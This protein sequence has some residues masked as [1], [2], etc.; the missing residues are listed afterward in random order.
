MD[1]Q[2]D[3]IPVDDNLFNC[4]PE[5]LRHFKEDY[6]PSGYLSV[7]HTFRKGESGRWQ[8]HWLLKAEDME[9]TYRHFAYPIERITGTAD[10]EYDNDMQPAIKL[11]LAGYSRDRRVTLTGSV[12]IA[13]VNSGVDLNIA[14]ENVPLDDKL[15]KALPEASQRL[16]D[17]FRPDKNRKKGAAFPLIGFGD[18]KVELRR[19]RGCPDLNKS[20]FI[21]FHDATLCYDVF[22]YPLENVSGVLALLPDHWEAKHFRSTHNGGEITFTPIRN[23]SPATRA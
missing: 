14:A 6:S 15:Y 1:C 22:P 16:V 23:R 4:L 5:N 8:K 10:I 7:T 12:Q 17:L 11:D 13:K 19:R 2:L 21:T 3:H 18:L 20:F 9:G